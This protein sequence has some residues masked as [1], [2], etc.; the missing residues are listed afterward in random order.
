[1]KL[2]AREPRTPRRQ[3]AEVLGQEAAESESVF[4]PERD[5]PTGYRQEWLRAIDKPFNGHR[6]AAEE[7]AAQYVLTFPERASDVD[8]DKIWKKH[9]PLSRVDDYFYLLVL[10]PNRQKEIKQKM[11][12][13]FGPNLINTEMR[14]TNQDNWA[15]LS[16]LLRVLF[17]DQLFR[18]LPNM[19]KHWTSESEHGP[20]PP[21]LTHL[22]LLVDARLMFPERFKQLKP[23]PEHVRALKGKVMEALETWKRRTQPEINLHSARF[24]TNLC[25]LLADEINIHPMGGLEVIHRKQHRLRQ[26]TSLPIRPEV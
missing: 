1:M 15:R 8:L 24:V 16:V 9:V 13:K 12:E 5:L 14:G 11:E 19:E 25:L 26:A 6:A 23:S 2:Q 20:F 21:G 10:F 17:P 4:D 22:S 18:H 7:L 3:S